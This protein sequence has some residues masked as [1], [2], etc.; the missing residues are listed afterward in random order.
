MLGVTRERKAAA[1]GG[2]AS[3]AIQG[4]RGGGP[5]TQGDGSPGLDPDL[6]ATIRRL[7]MAKDAD[8]ASGECIE[9]VV[10]KPARVTNHEDLLPPAMEDMGSGT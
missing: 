4:T 5:P 9:G 1:S 3:T 6:L 10:A 8:L 2:R 7:E